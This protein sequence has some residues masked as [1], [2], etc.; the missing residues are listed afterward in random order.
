MALGSKRVTARC[1]AT[2]A[3]AVGARFAMDLAH[4]LGFVDL[5]LEGGV[6]L[7]INEVRKGDVC[8]V[9]ILV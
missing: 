3:E 5:V 2:L 9:L 1:N 4:R 6:M 8:L 7:V